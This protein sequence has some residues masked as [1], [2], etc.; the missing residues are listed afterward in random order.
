MSREDFPRVYELRDLIEDPRSP[1]AYF[2]DFEA[3]VRA[4]PLKR[5]VW[6][7]REQELQRLDADPWRCLKNEAIPYLMKRDPNGRG[8]QQLITI[9]NQAR[10]FNYL[11]SIGCSAIQYVPRAA[12]QGL[13]TPD[14]Q[15]TLDGRMV[16]CEVKT[17]NVS[18][19]EAFARRD[20]TAR[21]IAGSLEQGFFNK[22]TSDLKKA[23]K[24]MESYAGA[25]DVRRIAYVICNFDDLFAEYKEGHYR[26]IDQHLADNPCSEIEI[27]FHNER[28]CF[29]QQIMMRCATVINERA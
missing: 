10:A 21:A 5:Q 6:L 16:L 26:Q 15:G 19:Q 1:S 4:E 20:G 29:H 27:V 25:N 3:S 14:L 13:D 17:I 9:L 24:Q 2:Q 28:T 22:L 23:K 7:A 18:N 12:A 8:W 11:K